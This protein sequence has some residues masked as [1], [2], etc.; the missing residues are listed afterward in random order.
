MLAAELNLKTAIGSNAK[1]AKQQGCQGNLRRQNPHLLGKSRLSQYPFPF[2][3][4]RVFRSFNYGN[5]G[6]I[7]ATTCATRSGERGG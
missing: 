2:G 6:E 5:R 1:Y 7:Q 4:F 3:R